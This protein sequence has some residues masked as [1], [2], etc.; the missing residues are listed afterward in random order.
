MSRIV[1]LSE[2]VSIAFHSMVLVA[3]SDKPLNVLEISEKISSSK[4][5][6]AKVMQ[7]LVKAGFVGS[8]RGPAGGFS[9]KKNA[10]DINLL[11]IYEAIEGTL[12]TGA[13]LMDKPVC[14]FETC[15][16]SNIIEKM[17]CDFKNYLQNQKLSNY[18]KCPI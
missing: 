9:L 12:E 11:S 8:L 6:V 1:H 2:A 4:H 5:H 3:R 14:S 10:S 16:Y 13:C 18:Y 15:I 7:R 17:T